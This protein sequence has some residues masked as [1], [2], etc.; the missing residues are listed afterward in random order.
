MC[1]L[2]S[3]TKGQAAIIALVR[4]MRDRTG[5]LPPMPGVFPDFM[6]PG[7]MRPMAFANWRWRDGACRVRQV[8]AARPSPIHRHDDGI[9]GERL[10]WLIHQNHRWGISDFHWFQVSQ[11]AALRGLT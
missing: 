9:R 11:V 4:A 5:N 10:S 8:S 7:V 6:A 1:N 3:L 2:Y